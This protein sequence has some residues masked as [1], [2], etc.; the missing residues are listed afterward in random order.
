MSFRN[1]KFLTTTVVCATVTIGLSIPLGRLA[2]RAQETPADQL[3]ALKGD[4]ETIYARDCAS[5]H[6]AEGTSDGAGP[7]LDGNNN[8]ANKEHVIK[9]ILGGS[10]EKGME[11]FG[12]TLS[13]HD[14]AAAATYV[15]NAWNNTFG[16]VLE[17]DVAPLRAQLKIEKKK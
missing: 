7:A 15:R 16:V 3:E 9:R 11:A 17:S 6:G 1:S 12:K 10:P 14:I 8:L 5:C 4:G 13:D 2:A